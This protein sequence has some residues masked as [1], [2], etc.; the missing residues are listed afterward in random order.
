MELIYGVYLQYLYFGPFFV[1]VLALSRLISKQRYRINYFYSLSYIFM[2]LGMVQ[3]ITYSVQPYE[4]YWYVSHFLI[5]FTFGTPLF[6]YLRFRFLIQGVTIRIH[7]LILIILFLT[8]VF[9]ALGPLSASGIMF[10]KEYARLRPLA[11]PSFASLPAYFQCVHILNFS[12]KLILGAGLLTLLVKT[13]Y[14]WSA[15]DSDRLILVRTTYIFTVMMFLTSV[16]AIAGDLFSFELTRA[17]AAMV[18]TVTLGIFFVSQYDPGYYTIFKHL[19]QKK[20]YAVSKVRS[21]DV[22][23]VIDRLR[24]L[25]EEEQLYMEEGLS[26]KTVSGLLDVSPQQL[27]EILNSEL[28]RSF[29][30]YINDF[31]IAGAKKLLVDRSELTVIRIAM[32]TG[33]NSLRTFNRVFVKSTGVSP[34]EY[35]NC[36]LI[37]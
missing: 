34:V 25:M 35:R 31:K 12:A 23:S 13:A 6:L 33:F 22:N 17:A 9:I 3:V 32:M 24:T 20:K 36:R 8:T 11:D 18:N 7:P 5:P 28:N 4:G 14:L 19:P 37:K 21:L 29:S 10:V 2:G 1:L 26:I 16:L 30:T 27:S 15:I